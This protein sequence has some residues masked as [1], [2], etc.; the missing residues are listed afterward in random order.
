MAQTLAFAAAER[1]DLAAMQKAVQDCL[2]HR[3]HV[4]NIQEASYRMR[5]YRSRNKTWEKV[6]KADE[7][8]FQGANPPPEVDRSGTF[9]LDIDIEWSNGCRLGTRRRK[10][11]SFLLGRSRDL[12]PPP[13][14][15]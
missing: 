10:N 7:N 12:R 3:C 15:Q 14:H 9:F 4:V 1:D 2:L 13:R 6:Q 5:E 8:F 11:H